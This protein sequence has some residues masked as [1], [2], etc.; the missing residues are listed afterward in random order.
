[1]NNL[2]SIILE[3]ET[4]KDSSYGFIENDKITECD[5]ILKCKRMEY[6]AAAGERVEVVCN[7]PCRA[8]G[9]VAS[10]VDKMLNKKD[11]QGLRVVGLLKEADGKLWVTCEHI[12]K[13]SKRTK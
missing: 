3:G 9:D 4:I 7:I 8:F 6:N 11:V 13:F 12:D 2:N 10:K 5:F 1:M